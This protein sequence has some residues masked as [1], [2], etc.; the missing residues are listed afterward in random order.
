MSAVNIADMSRPGAQRGSRYHHGNL[1]EV[2]EQTALDLVA[3]KG[4]H[5][6]TLA[7]A[8]RRAG[9]SVAAPFK[10]YSG[11]EALLAALAVR[12]YE[13]QA[14][15]YAAAVAKSND[16]VEKMAEFAGAYVRFAID[17][18]AQFEITFSGGVD[19]RVYPELEQAGRHVLDLLQEPARALRPNP[20]E[21]LSLIYAVSACAH[22]FAAF[23]A[24]GVFGDPRQRTGAQVDAVTARARSAA[25]LLARTQL[26]PPPDE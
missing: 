8:S 4:A 16:P 6:F 20:D 11:K 26:C 7:E 18:P 9:V 17:E 24:Q 23:F 2:L 5:G 14:R 1:R 25:R 19:K 12:G 3:E 10:H 22:G 21:A 15:R 13:E